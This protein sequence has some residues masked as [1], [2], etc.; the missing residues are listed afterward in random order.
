[1]LLFSLLLPP[2]LISL[3]QTISKIRQL[4]SVVQSAITHFSNLTPGSDSHI[5]PNDAV[6]D[7]STPS[8]DA[9]APPAKVSPVKKEETKKELYQRLVLDG[10]PGWAAIHNDE[11]WELDDTD[12]VWFLWFSK[13]NGYDLWW[14]EADEE[15]GTSCIHVDETDLVYRDTAVEVLL[16]QEKRL[17]SASS[18]APSSS[19]PPSKAT[20]SMPPADS[21]LFASEAPVPPPPSHAHFVFVTCSSLDPERTG[22]LCDR[23]FAIQE[24]LPMLYVITRNTTV[25]QPQAQAEPEIVETVP[26][27][28]V[29]DSGVV[30]Q[31]VEDHVVRMGDDAEGEIKPEDGHPPQ[32]PQLPQPI[33][34]HNLVLRKV[35]LD[36]NLTVSG[37]RN[38]YEFKRWEK[39]P[40]WDNALNPIDGPIGTAF[41]GKVGE[42][43][44]KAYG[45][46]YT[47]PK[48]L[49]GFFL[50]LILQQITR[51]VLNKNHER[52]EKKKEKKKEKKE[53]ERREREASVVPPQII[54]E[55]APVVRAR[56]VEPSTAGFPPAEPPIAEE[57]PPM[58]Q[59][60]PSVEEERLPV[61][62]TQTQ[63]AVDQLP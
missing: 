24:H 51:R 20:K 33:I 44:G 35:P 19:T 34:K 56:S 22:G 26:A 25:I 29:D 53:A 59:A 61:A 30:Q 48:W 37:L 16:A 49:V 12:H 4:P 40:V 21:T 43:L 27:E 13:M 54:V 36:G 46:W 58:V 62:Q 63:P 2:L 8:P 47:M 39:L 7:I 3:P 14:D 32:P 11:A 55:E 23:F 42:I 50:A 5:L 1:M 60:E 28:V 18:A 15:C 6:H 52:R 9:D 45:I 41:D 38:F 31:Q 57:Q 10:I 17:Q